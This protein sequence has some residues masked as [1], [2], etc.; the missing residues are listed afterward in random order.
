MSI[1]QIASLIVAATTILSTLA[2]IIVGL[3]KIIEGQKCLLRSEMLRIYYHHQEA[4]VI[5]QFEFEN[6]AALYAAYKRLKGNSFADKINKE[7]ATE[8]KVVS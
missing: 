6:F 2:G 7:I 3:M 4:K 1:E 5:R 8:W